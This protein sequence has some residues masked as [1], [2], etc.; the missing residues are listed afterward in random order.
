MKSQRILNAFLLA[1]PVALSGCASNTYNV[2]KDN[3]V[4]WNEGSLK[5]PLLI[6]FGA[7][8][9]GSIDQTCQAG[10]KIGYAA[11]MARQDNGIL[12]PA[13]LVTWHKQYKELID[14]INQ[15]PS[16]NATLL[17][18]RYFADY[19]IREGS[20]AF[21]KS[22]ITSEMAKAMYDQKILDPLQFAPDGTFAPPESKTPEAKKICTG[23]GLFRVC[24]T[25][26]PTP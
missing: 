12:H 24:N 15:A 14:Q 6:E 9:Q 20:T 25:E 23:K 13:S 10:K 5:L 18:T 26:T 7:K 22:M 11:L 16:D 3:C 1:V 8:S 21:G 19:F 4:A 2:N 17:Q